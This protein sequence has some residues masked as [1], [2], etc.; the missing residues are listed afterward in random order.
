MI[1]LLLFVVWLEKKI[2]IVL[3]GSIA[4][5]KTGYIEAKRYEFLYEEEMYENKA[6]TLNHDLIA[7]PDCIL[8][9]IGL[10]K[11][12]EVLGGNIE[13]IQKQ[14]LEKSNFENIAFFKNLSE[15]KI[16][17]LESKLEIETFDNGRKII[18]QGEIGDKF[19]IIKSGRVDFFVNSKYVRS[20]NDG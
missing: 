9:E 10:D 13:K 15:D 19:Y 6:I 7:D 3:E 16:E 17:L 5:K 11:F 8:A 18:S 12:Q 1:Y 4:N 20:L 14:A 2:Y